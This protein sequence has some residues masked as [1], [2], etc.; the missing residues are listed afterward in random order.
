MDLI[1]LLDLPL[2]DPKIIELLEHWDTPVI[3]DFDRLFENQPDIYW[4]SAHAEG[5]LL[6]FNESQKLET[7]FVYLQGTD[8][9]RPY[10]DNP[11][12][13]KLFSTFADAKRYATRHDLAH[14]QHN[15]SRGIPP[16]IRF[17]YPS[18]HVHYQFNDTG[19]FRTT[20]MTASSAPS[21]P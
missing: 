1:P 15:E 11:P 8:E 17:E 12:D 19:L 20:L 9:Y 10:S 16:W 7:I 2:K 4:A 5:L 14:S 18:H 6:R 13:F 3:Y 21:S